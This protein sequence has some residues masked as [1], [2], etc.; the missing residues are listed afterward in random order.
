MVLVSL[1][2]DCV[3]KARAGEPQEVMAA[4]AIPI[5]KTL[6]EY[7]LANA[8]NMYRFTCDCHRNQKISALGN[9]PGQG[10]PWPT[11]LFRPPE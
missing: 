6:H 4:H 5:V 3:I 1:F 9:I 2:P 11:A 8:I 7:P 10:L